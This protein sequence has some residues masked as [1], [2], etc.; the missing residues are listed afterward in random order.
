MKLTKEVRT[1]LNRLYLTPSEPSS[2]GGVH[3]LLIYA[4]RHDI[5][6]GQVRNYLQRLEGYTQHKQVRRKFARR[7][8]ICVDSRDQYQI[9]L[10]DM[11]KFS[12]ENDN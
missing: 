12:E 10:A 6:E 4:E 11:Q 2:L 1:V 3:C 7:K 8:I 9:D 5:S